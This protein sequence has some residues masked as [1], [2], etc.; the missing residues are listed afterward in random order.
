MFRLPQFPLDPA[1]LGTGREH[2][3]VCHLGHPEGHVDT[4]WDALSTTAAS[5]GAGAG[6]PRV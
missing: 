4:I 2:R 1:L 6:G 3:P 5:I